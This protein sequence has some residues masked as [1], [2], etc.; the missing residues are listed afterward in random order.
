MQDAK[1]RTKQYKKN[2]A[3]GEAC[4]RK[5]VVYENFCTLYSIFQ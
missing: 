5:G 1:N 3:Q 2:C 4:Q